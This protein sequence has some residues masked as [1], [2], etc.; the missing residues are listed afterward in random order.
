MPWEANG[1]VLKTG[2]YLP[3]GHKSLFA[4]ALR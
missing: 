3:I 2:H 4:K 1:F